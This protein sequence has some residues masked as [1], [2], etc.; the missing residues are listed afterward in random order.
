MEAPMRVL[1][2]DGVAEAA[3]P[4]EEL[5]GRLR[6][7]DGW[8]VV[9][10]QRARL[11]AQLRA[12]IEVVE[13]RAGKALLRRGIVVGGRATGS[14]G[15]ALPV[16]PVASVTSL[17]VADGGGWEAVDLAGSRLLPDLH[18]PVLELA[19][20]PSSGRLLRASLVAGWADWAEVP[21]ALR[22]AV[23]LL[24]EAMERG[25]MM[26]VMAELRALLGTW[27]QRRIGAAT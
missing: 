24:A 12:A 3:L 13:T 15:L 1:E 4:V 25:E 6:L 7:P 9:P 20:A 5:A 14:A 11:V 23:L 2:R 8:D 21:P 19:S 17:E 22:A 18:R 26:G 16:A 27:R 10:G